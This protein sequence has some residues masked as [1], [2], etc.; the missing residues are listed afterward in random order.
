MA[1]HIDI[2]AHLRDRELIKEGEKILQLI[3]HYE[4][5]A[6]RRATAGA[7]GRSKKIIAAEDKVAA[8]FDRTT[9][10]I[11]EFTA[12]TARFERGQASLDEIGNRTIR[13]V[14]DLAAAENDWEQA[15]K[16]V[17]R[18]AQ[19]LIY[20]GQALTKTINDETRATADL[21]DE[22]RAYT[23]NAKEVTRITNINRKQ[24]T[25]LSRTTNKLRRDTQN[26]HAANITIFQDNTKIA[27]SM[28][29]LADLTEKAARAQEKYDEIR[30]K[31][32][33]TGAQIK[34]QGRILRD[35]KE[36][37]ARKARDVQEELVKVIEQRR[38]HSSVVTQNET[39]L[40]RLADESFQLQR[41]SINLRSVNQDVIDQ[42]ITLTRQ[43][44]RVGDSVMRVAEEYREYHEMSQD[45]SV[46]SD[47]LEE[48]I[49][50]INK[51]FVAQQRAVRDAE[52]VLEDYY[53]RQQEGEKRAAEAAKRK[54]NIELRKIQPQSMGQY[55]SRNL[56]ALTPLGTL[57]PST[58][59]PLAG[60]LGSVG[61]A[62]VTA[63]QSLALLP[64]AGVA[65]A[66]GIGTLVV[67]MKGF[68]DALSGMGDPKKFAEALYL[69]SPNAQQAALRIKELVDG[70]LGDLKRA[71]Q[72]ALFADVG[73][74]IQ[75]L[76]GALGPA[77][78]R[79]TTS[80]ATSFNQMFTGISFQMMT[81]DMQ[82]RF[83]TITTNISAMFDRMVPAVTA[84]NSAFMKI[85]ETGSGFLP[86]LADS[87]ANVMNKFDAFITRA[88][89]DGSLQNF[90][91]KGIDAFAALSKWLLGFGQEIYEV[92]GNKSPEEFMNT[93]NGIKEVVIGLG[94]L[95][96]TV[97]DVMN[98][99]GPV[100]GEIVDSLG[101]FE[102]VLYALV[103]FGFAAWLA[104]VFMLFKNLKTLLGPSFVALIGRI[105]GAFGLIGPAAATAAATTTTAFGGAGTTAASKYGKAF[106]L[107]LKA[108]P[109]VGF[110][111]MISELIGQGLRDG[112]GGWRDAI[113][114]GLDPGKIFNPEYWIDK[115]F[116]GAAPA[117]TDD[118]SP[119]STASGSR[120]RPFDDRNPFKDRQLRG[121]DPQTGLP[122]GPPIDPVTG[123][124]VPLDKNGKAMSESDIL[125]QARGE[126]LPESY[127]VDPFTDPITG[128]KLNPMLPI[129]P[130]GMPEYPAGGVPGTPSIQG[131]IMP[132]YNSFGQ[133]TGY[134]ANMVDPEGVF[135]AQLAVIDRAGDLEESN[136][137]LL[138]AQKTGVLSA[139][140]INDL[141]RKVME[142]RISLHKALIELGKEQTGDIEKLKTATS[143]VANTLG[144]FSAEIDK[145]FGISKG[146]PG[147]AKNLTMFLASL[148][149]AP[150]FGAMRGAQS[151]LG[152]PG[153]EG[154]G[155]GLMG[156]LAVS[157]GYYK[158]G[159]RD[160]AAQAQNA[161]PVIPADT[162]SIPV[163]TASTPAST[164][165]S[166][167]AAVTSPS[168]PAAGAPRLALNPNNKS[169][170]GLKP[171]SLALLSLIQG[172]PQFANVKLG[173]GYRAP[174]D[175][176]DRKPGGGT[177]PWHPS[178][179]GL[180]LSLNAYD[181]VQSVQGDLL[182]SYLMQNKA[183]FGINDVLWKVKDHFDHLH[184]QLNGSGN[185]K[186]D[187]SPLLQSLG[188]AVPSVGTTPSL[189]SLSTGIPIPLPVTIVGSGMPGGL[190]S[191]LPGITPPPPGT[192]AA[193]A[194]PSGPQPVL[195]AAGA[196]AAQGSPTG[197][198]PGSSGYMMDDI[199]GG[200]I[201]KY[202]TVQPD[203][204]I[205]WRGLNGSPTKAPAGQ[206][207][208]PATTAPTAW[209]PPASAPAAG[210]TPIQP[211]A[212]TLP[213]P[214]LIP[215][216]F[217]KGG[218]VPIIAHSGEHV[219]TTRDVAAMGGQAGVYNF[220]RSLHYKVGGAV[221]RTPFSPD[222]FDPSNIPTPP[223]GPPN[224]KDIIR[225]TDLGS[226]LGV[227]DNP[228]A[229]PAPKVPT[230]PAPTVPTVPAP[231][232]PEVPVVSAPVVPAPALPALPE[233]VLPPGTETPGSVIGAQAQAPAGYGGGFDITGGGLV[234]LAQ[235]GLIAAA[236]SGAGMAGAGAAM[237]AGG[238]GGMGA[239]SGAA[240]AIAS[241]GMETAIKLGMRGIE[242]GAEVAGIGVQGLLETF[243]PAGGS[244]LA[245]N[246][247]ITRIVGGI[248]GAA[249]AM[250]NLAGG[251][252][253][254]TLPGVGS[255]TPE[256]IAA[257]GM[258]PN[259]TQHTGAGAPAGPVNNIGV[260]IMEYRTE[261]NRPASQDFGRYAIP[262][263]R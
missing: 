120:R 201:K 178:G 16:E 17:A 243:L 186:P 3:R 222:P 117:R 203:S 213:L 86:G 111:V 116:P 79:M 11:D 127:A 27:K 24:L 85:A 25:Q 110:G 148:A 121:V 54:R 126:L 78:Q 227:G 244:E 198:K 36:A 137:D 31:E 52:F 161:T 122:L 230:V 260:Q 101:G 4:D 242:Y 12:A 67:G 232:V 15:Q 174:G 60:V 57:S 136:K 93:L 164:S 210:P 195:P 184:I 23:R 100:I 147:I 124:P 49:K 42:N 32:G 34:A 26:L 160:T 172:M 236:S 59:L 248:A 37:E 38:E 247:W 171:Q 176:A 204:K 251:T 63:S 218:E 252:N 75:K 154:T 45:A 249:P 167:P 55:F 215:K 211:T 185:G 9:N 177:Y 197:A 237:G 223:S 8:A 170:A 168:T 92:F 179:T 214:P 208:S 33:V 181:R 58:L 20:K 206:P 146:L 140:E 219:L 257:Q 188:G 28:E 150:A 193:P 125:N 142:D 40:R 89:N 39:A 163:G 182:K 199:G 224:P 194:N 29:S 109:W 119:E 130:N 123:K 87:L 229:A 143:D 44:D 159:P 240:S 135:D 61:E 47:A 53:K 69:L 97:A 231:T 141:E 104:K 68:G 84:F 5:E 94:K 102:N 95:L 81:P 233:T 112:S 43:F 256:Q 138:A 131:P 149:F 196:P 250:A 139:E 48:K 217:A 241:L 209:P 262:G 226:L 200:P 216:K 239:G 134:G 115:F 108:L 71:T 175:P 192:P 157:M 202:W 221:P 56:G 83:G 99:W 212:P 51:A 30:K 35:A 96:V 259:R 145:D 158:G 14:E 151:A 98:K 64:A 155:S 118:P 80:I 82:A 77:I 74:T 189:A 263:Q 7:Q 72:D 113:S 103:G 6:N 105:A 50:S 254:S 70:P 21:N 220:R 65:A 245:S 114:D 66:A 62:A 152:F 90:M 153:G 41:R 238:G 234:G 166:T 191:G 190:L 180:D 246:N 76:T 91:Q 225:P 261:D 144:D 235:Q 129:G 207:G 18:A 258:D 1:I 173:S 132:Q 255:P 183:Y 46:S 187:T 162:T 205:V 107:G 88:Q 169:T 22:N 2:Y 19:D 165:A 228:P 73:V 133:L 156:A 13:T 106:K 128:Q 253:Q 10:K